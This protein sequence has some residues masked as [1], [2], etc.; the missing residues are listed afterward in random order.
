MANPDPIDAF[1]SRMAKITRRRVERFW[2]KRDV[3]F[4]KKYA[5]L[6]YAWSDIAENLPCGARSEHAVRQ[7]AAALNCHK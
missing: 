2:S 7:K 5:A 4:L 3:A 6:G 1:E